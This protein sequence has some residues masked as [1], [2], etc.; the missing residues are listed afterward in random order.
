MGKYKAGV[1]DQLILPGRVSVVAGRREALQLAGRAIP[2]P[3]AVRLM[4][5]TGSRRSSLIPGI[6]NRLGAH[7]GG[8]VRVE[9]SLA[10]V[11]ADLFWVQLEFPGTGLSPVPETLM[12][13]L[14]LPPR[15]HDFH[16]VIGRDLLSRWEYLLY[17]GRRGRLTVRDSPSLWSW[18]PR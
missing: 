14:P 7:L 13:R 3:E 1:Q 10:S 6:I 16:G 18:L 12:T 8:A 2:S 4:I 5:D 15:L 17:E 11:R 9:T